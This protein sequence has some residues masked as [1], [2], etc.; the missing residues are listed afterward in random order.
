MIRD[1]IKQQETN[2][3]GHLENSITD[4]SSRKNAKKE[5]FL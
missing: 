4:Y 2:M 5:M 1:F 3:I